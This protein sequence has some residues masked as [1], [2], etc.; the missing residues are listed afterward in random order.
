MLVRGVIVDDGVDE[1]AGGNRSLHGVEE[2]DEPLMAMLVHA[3]AYT[4]AASILSAANKLVV[5][6]RL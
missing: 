3:A 2:T 1:L 4:V 6:L 5:P